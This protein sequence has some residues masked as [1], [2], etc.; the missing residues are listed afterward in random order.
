MSGFFETNCDMLLFNS[1]H[2]AFQAGQSDTTNSGRVLIE[3]KRL[4]V[5][6]K[7]ILLYGTIDRLLAQARF[8][9]VQVHALSLLQFKPSEPCT[10]YSTWKNILGQHPA[11]LGYLLM[12]THGTCTYN[13]SNYFKTEQFD[14]I[15]MI[16]EIERTLF[17]L[18]HLE[19]GICFCKTCGG[20]IA[21]ERV[22]AIPGVNKCIT[23][24][25]LEEAH[26]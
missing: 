24:K 8:P 13:C 5:A 25:Y 19:L 9:H 16:I 11:F 2:H 10:V 7:H 22:K 21:A 26:G 23:C 4:E 20:P 6:A 1:C 3:V 15:L 12:S 14:S 17:S 18:E